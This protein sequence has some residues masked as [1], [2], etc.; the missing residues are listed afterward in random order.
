MRVIDAALVRKPLPPGYGVE[1]YLNLTFAD[2]GHKIAIVDL[3][4]LRGPLRGYAN[5]Q[6]SAIAVTTEILDF[7]VLSG[8]LDAGQRPHWDRWVGH[9]LDA[10][11]VPPQPGAADGEHLAAVAAVGNRP[12]PPAQAR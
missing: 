7:A 3:G 4:F 8:R 9:V 12:L 2:A 1:T 10:I 11:G 5:V 6:E